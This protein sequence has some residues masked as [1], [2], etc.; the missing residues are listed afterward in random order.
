MML[1]DVF[2]MLR[3]FLDITDMLSLCNGDVST[4][5]MNWLYAIEIRP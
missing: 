1:R 2:L 4:C 5:E 3:I